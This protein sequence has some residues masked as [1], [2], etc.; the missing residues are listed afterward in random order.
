MNAAVEKLTRI[1]QLWKEIGRTKSKTP[2]Y[3]TL[4]AKIRTLSAES[5][6]PRR[7]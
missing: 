1:Q 6:A 2:E 5:G 4:M 3:E 7:F